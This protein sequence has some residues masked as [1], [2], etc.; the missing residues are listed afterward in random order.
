MLIKE[1]RSE[2]LL[3]LNL[4]IDVLWTLTGLCLCVVFKEA[5]IQLQNLWPQKD[6]KTKRNLNKDTQPQ[7]FMSYLKVL[8]SFE[9]I[10]RCKYH[11]CI[12]L[13]QT[14]IIKP[15]LLLDKI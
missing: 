5:C 1:L 14:A 3:S 15:T 4:K 6:I 2:T 9:I 10:S 11:L 8:L 7:L 12:K 13:L